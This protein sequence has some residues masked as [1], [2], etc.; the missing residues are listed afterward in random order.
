M[1]KICILVPAVLIISILLTWVNAEAAM[2]TSEVDQEILSGQTVIDNS[3]TYFTSYTEPITREGFCYLMV[4][5]LA[6]QQGISVDSMYSGLT[7]TQKDNAFDDV[8]EEN[9]YISLAKKYE[10]IVG[11]GDR[12]FSPQ[13]E[14]TRQ[15]AALIFYNYVI[16]FSPNHLALASE[17]P[18]VIEDHVEIADWARTAVDYVVSCQLMPLDQNGN[19]DPLHTITVE[20]A[21]L[22][23][24]DFR[25]LIESNVPDENV[26]QENPELPVMFLSVFGG[27]AGILLAAVLILV[28]RRRHRQTLQMRSDEEQ[29]RMDALVHKIVPSDSE[30]EQIM[31]Q[32]R[33]NSDTVLLEQSNN[34][35]T[36]QIRLVDIVGNAINK[37][38]LL[39]PYITV[40]R[41]PE[42]TVQLQEKTVSSNHCKIY[43]DGV[44]VILEKTGARNP[45]R[46]ERN[47]AVIQ[48]LEDRP[49]SVL[50]GDILH[51]GS[52]RI[53]VT[54]SGF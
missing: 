23:T 51:L 33:S 5:L 24:T 47:G 37:T 8:A 12:Y 11:I 21:I 54:L 35:K 6:Q 28:L 52:L 40:G 48:M 20:D 4:S 44:R 18:N 50:D 9:K 22:L 27:V 1:K 32:E 43:Y 19:F 42:N 53:R 15:E 3:D 26:V 41:T 17:E 46:I 2:N 38:F 34:K 30:A 10:L 14:I 7:E 29:R 36:V 39:D 25:M 16:K 13:T 49:L 31:Q 45:I